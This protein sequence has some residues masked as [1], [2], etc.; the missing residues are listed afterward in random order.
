MS[1]E[2]AIEW[3]GGTWNP[4][5]GCTK[6]S[7]GCKGC[8]MYVAKRR[9]GQD[10]TVV[11]RSKTKFDEP[12]RWRESRMI[13]TCSW[14][15]WFHATADAWRNE[16][17][18][19]IR[20]TPQ[21]TYQI[22]TKRPERVLDHLPPDWGRGWPNVWLGV[23][24]EDTNVIHRV[25]ILQRAPAEVRFLSIEP[26]I[27]SVGRL[28]LGGIGWVIVG[29]ESGPGHRP[30]RPEWVRSVRDQCTEA[31]VSFFFKQWGGKTPKAG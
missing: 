8:Y 15:D 14:S 18:G 13:F 6:V 10:P 11:V 1:Y 20:A 9:Y 27:G 22:L 7:A 2:S 26:L 4:W 24:I 3:T 16:A 19:V 30:C 31:G 28:N 25:A 12:L 5:H 17:W 29:G 23:S 21:H